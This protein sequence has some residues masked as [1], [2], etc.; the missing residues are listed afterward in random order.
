MK[1]GIVGCSDGIVKESFFS[2][3]NDLGKSL[4]S[5]GL[6]PVFSPF[7]EAKNGFFSGTDEER[8]QALMDFYKNPEITEIFDMSGGDLANGVL[9]FLDYEIIKTSEKR[10]WGY[11][12]LTTVLN[13][14]YT[15]TGKK[16]NLYSIKNLLFDKSGQQKK[17][18]SDYLFGKN[19]NL[20]KP[21]IQMIRGEKMEGELIGGNI[22]CFLKL[23]GT[24]YF[25]ETEGKILFLEACGGNE[26]K[27]ATFMSQLKQMKIL[28]ELSGILFG[29]FTEYLK[30]KT[31]EEL[32]Q[33]LLSYLPETLPI[34][35]TE[36][37]GH[38]KLSKALVI[39]NKLKIS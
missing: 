35:V 9:S 24:E 7:I 11:S 6:E 19:H 36:E 31:R 26:A 3:K 29:T 17:D 34:A 20:I 25:P 38:G 30:E 22:R 39:G 37:V 15:K 32:N 23:A 1:I 5:L 27:I 4:E 21:K 2:L 10:Y 8:A 16:N 28:E 13:A 14:I 33:L 18:L 12:D